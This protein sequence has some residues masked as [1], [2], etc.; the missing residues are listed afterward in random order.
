MIKINFINIETI[1]YMDIEFEQII[2]I[3]NYLNKSTL[4][5]TLINFK[6]N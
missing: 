2:I 3:C 1:Y 6:K 4:Q 5:L